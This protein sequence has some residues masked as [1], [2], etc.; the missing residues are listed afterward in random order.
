MPQRTSMAIANSNTAPT[1]IAD[2]PVWNSEPD[3]PIGQE[4]DDYRPHQRFA[5]RTAPAAEAVAAEE[6]RRHDREFEA[7]AGVGADA[8]KPRRIEYARKA[9][10]HAGDDI[11]QAH[12]ASHRDAGVVGRTTRSADRHDAPADAQPSQNDMSRY[13]NDDQNHELTGTP[14]IDPVPTKSKRSESTLLEAIGTE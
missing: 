8:G 10:E 11:G 4:R 2:A 13:R 12:R 1:T 14:R 9:G 5:D 3:E 6:R 7:D